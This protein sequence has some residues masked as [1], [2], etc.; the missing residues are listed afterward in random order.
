MS[1]TLV[2]V[3]A[4]TCVLGCT[5]LASPY[6][7]SPA[8]SPSDQEWRVIVSRTGN[9]NGTTTFVLTATNSGTAEQVLFTPG[10]SSPAIY[11]R[12]GGIHLQGWRPSRRGAEA[13][14]DYVVLWPGEGF[15]RATDALTPEQLSQI[16]AIGGAL[17]IYEK[18]LESHSDKVARVVEAPHHNIRN[19]GG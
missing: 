12:L 17:I 11:P 10:L 9:P 19:A 18:G 8:S 13:S 15:S 5:P 4:V 2:R 1:G 16:D 6:Q 14:R 3:V 7:G